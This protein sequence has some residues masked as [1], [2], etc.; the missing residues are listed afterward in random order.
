MA[1]ASKKKIIAVLNLHF[2]TVVTAD[3]SMKGAD[4]AHFC[5]SYEKN[6]RCLLLYEKHH[7]S[8]S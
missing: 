1:L 7:K 4:S 2:F 5:R 6:N 8:K 3:K